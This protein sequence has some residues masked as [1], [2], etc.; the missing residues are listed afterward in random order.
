MKF[1][2]LA[3]ALIAPMNAD[4]NMAP[5]PKLES[6][7]C[8]SLTIGDG[9]EIFDD[10]ADVGVLPSQYRQ[11]AYMRASRPH[12]GAVPRGG[13][14]IQRGLPA[15]R[16]IPRVPGAPA[17]GLRLQPMG[18]PVTTFT[19][20]SGTALSAV[21]RPQRPF[22][23]KRLVVDIARNGTTATGLVSVAG[24]F[25]GTNNQFVSLGAIGAG[26]FAPGA[27]DTNMELCAST[28]ALDIT[29][30]YALSNA[31]TMTDTVVVGTTLIGE[32]VG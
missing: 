27:Y 15:G 9:A 4:L 12:W 11:P 13:Y 1:R 23:P 2:N 19:A 30:Q 17:I 20:T 5:E 16:L 10:L 21:Q 31:P 6:S 32:A 28:T 18:F 14:G 29:V 24:L 22:K 7:I 26:A 3:M 25:I 8:N